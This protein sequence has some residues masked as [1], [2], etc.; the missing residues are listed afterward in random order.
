MSYGLVM[1]RLASG[2]RATHMPK[3]QVTSL[4]PSEPA[5]PPSKPMCRV[6]AQAAMPRLFTAHLRS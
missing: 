3:P 5:M 4:Q 1:A 2:L 6:S